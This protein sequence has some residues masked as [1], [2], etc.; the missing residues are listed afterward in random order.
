MCYLFIQEKLS[1]NS[2]VSVRK[3]R[4]TLTTFIRIKRANWGSFALDWLNII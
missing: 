1:Q 3:T 4:F 2:E